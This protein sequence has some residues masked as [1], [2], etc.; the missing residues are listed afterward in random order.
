MAI[1]V[2]TGAGVAGAESYASVAQADA[3]WSARTHDSRSTTWSDATTAVKEGALREATAYIDAIYGS[4]YLGRRRGYVQGL[5]WPRTGA[6]D[7]AGYEL[8][9]LPQVLVN[10]VSDLAVRAV[11]ARLAADLEYGGRVK[12]KREKIDVI[13]DET[14]YVDGAPATTLYGHVSGMLASI[15]NGLQPDAPPGGSATWFWR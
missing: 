8:P 2:E 1:T 9:D 15:L 4:F 13:E 12:R 6:L 14:E 3:Y 11:S 10:A 7:A 5:E